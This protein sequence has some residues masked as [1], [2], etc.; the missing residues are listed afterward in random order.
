M[1]ESP[2]AGAGDVDLTLVRKTPCASGQRG[3]C[4]LTTEPVGL[5]STP[6]EA[7]TATA[8]RPPPSAARDSPRAAAKTQLSR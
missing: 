6:G 7:Q 4:V 2:P 3:L 1:A 8:E 5:S